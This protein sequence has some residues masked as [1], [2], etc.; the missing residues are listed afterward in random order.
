ML[1]RLHSV[2]YEKTFNMNNSHFYILSKIGHL[3][4]IFLTYSL[5]LITLFLCLQKLCDVSTYIYIYCFFFNLNFIN[6]SIIFCH[7]YYIFKLILYLICYFRINKHDF[8]F[9]RTCTFFKWKYFFRFNV[10]TR[11]NTAFLFFLSLF[12]S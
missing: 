3:T 4:T 8:K 9:H 11:P 1:K 10:W 12:N 7:C 5:T 2:K 6:Y